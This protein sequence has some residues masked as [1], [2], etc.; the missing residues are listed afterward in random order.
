MSNRIPKYTTQAL[1]N[2]QYII[3]IFPS[4]YDSYSIYSQMDEIYCHG[5][6]DNI[7]DITLD[8]YYYKE[9]LQLITSLRFDKELKK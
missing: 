3:I 8:G 1:H 7:R 5:Y 6:T 2:N 9:D 4:V